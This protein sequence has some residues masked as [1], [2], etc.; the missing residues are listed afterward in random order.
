M[1][2]E[3]Q[4]GESEPVI[5]LIS[6]Q[7]VYIGSKDS[8][9]IVIKS[10]EIS[11]KHVKI[12][13]QENTWFI[14]DMGSTNGTFINEERLVPGRRTEFPLNETVTLAN[15]VSLKILA[16]VAG[17]KNPKD[18]DL[19]G[20]TTQAVPEGNK[21][22]LSNSDKTRVISLKEMQKA[23]KAR[24]IK[25]K[26]KILEKKREESKRMRAEKNALKR[27]SVIAAI[28]I[29]VGIV[30][31]M[32]WKHVPGMLRK[33]Y[34]PQKT[35]VD[36][37]LI[38][39]STEDY[40]EAFVIKEEFLNFRPELLA[41]LKKEK[42]KTKLENVFCS[43]LEEFNHVYSGVL[44]IKDHVAFY[45]QEKPW[46]DKAR[47]FLK[48]KHESQDLG[49]EDREV[50][51]ELVRKLAMIFFMREALGKTMPADF[52][53]RIFYLVFYS[54]DADIAYASA[55]R[56]D[57]LPHFSIKYELEE[58]KITNTNG[59]MLAENLSKFITVVQ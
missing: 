46:M 29:A 9:D 19:K 53:H 49:V 54:V 1:R 6:N 41:A 36:R 42:C 20:P 12:S 48:E 55:F 18:I 58:K 22:Q 11:G 8:N 14:T 33:A 17:E 59:H 44:E 28:W 35:S 52:R 39:A 43:K 10:S 21:A 15:Q 30:S 45:T 5:Y 50:D 23:Q 2:L 16:K 37:V 51:E 40:H 57:L 25:R 47:K 32:A 27:V 3:V 26:Q 34:A 4:I 56:S 7:D 31:Q 24:E 13:G 38:D